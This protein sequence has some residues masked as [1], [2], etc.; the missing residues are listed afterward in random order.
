MQT[1]VLDDHYPQCY[2]ATSAEMHVCM[3][4]GIVASL[5]ER[6]VEIRREFTFSRQAN[7]KGR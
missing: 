4:S 3:Q 7:R 6:N 2:P 5:S 1:N